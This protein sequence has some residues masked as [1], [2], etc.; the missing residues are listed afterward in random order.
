MYT[1]F[2]RSQGMSSLIAASAC[3]YVCTWTEKQ[4]L[5]PQYRALQKEQAVSVIIVFTYSYVGRHLNTTTVS[6]RAIFRRVP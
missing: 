5:V 6:S 2:R 1:L 3:A 4:A